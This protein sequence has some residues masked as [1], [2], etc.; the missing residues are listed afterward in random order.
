MKKRMNEVKIGEVF[1]LEGEP[2]IFELI[3]H[4]NLGNGEKYYILKFE[5]IGREQKLKFSKEEV[6]E[7]KLDFINIKVRQKKLL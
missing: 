2:A 4:I 6:E 7:K 5:L 1:D 3:E